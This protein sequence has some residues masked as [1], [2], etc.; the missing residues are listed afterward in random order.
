MKFFVS[1]TVPWYTNKPCIIHLW[2]FKGQE[3][4]GKYF[5]LSQIFGHRPKIIHL[6][7]LELFVTGYTWKSYFSIPSFRRQTKHSILPKIAPKKSFEVNHNIWIFTIPIYFN[8][9]PII[10]CINYFNNIHHTHTQKHYFHWNVE[11]IN[12]IFKS[13]TGSWVGWINT[14]IKMCIKILQGEN[15][16]KKN[17][18]P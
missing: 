4:Y 10:F 15:L 14:G 2:L 8:S 9:Y 3:I 6:Y 11:E 18:A 16:L 5:Y 7:I 1:T 12:T 13:E 17:T